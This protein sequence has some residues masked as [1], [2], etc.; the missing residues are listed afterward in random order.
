MTEVFAHLHVAIGLHHDVLRLDVAM[1]DVLV[2]GN[3]ERLAD[4]SADF[5]SLALIDGAALLNGGFQ[6]RS[7]DEFHDDIVGAVVL[8]PIVHVDDVGAL[9]VRCGS[10]LLAEALG[11]RGIGCKLGQ[12]HLYGHDASEREV[13]CAIDFS[14][15]ADADTVFNLVTAAE[16]L[17]R[18]CS[19]SGHLITP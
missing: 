7:A 18:H 17:T 5:S 12:H 19:L 8:T 14:H 6:I 2:M 9:Q 11:K 15:A 10:G 4:L 3:G 13:L 16:D 1:N